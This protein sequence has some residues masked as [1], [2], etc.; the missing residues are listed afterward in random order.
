MPLLPF[1]HYQRRFVR[2]LRER[3]RHS[4]KHP[5]LT[6]TLRVARSRWSLH[7]ISSRRVGLAVAA[8]A[9]LFPTAGLSEPSAQTTA[10]HLY[11]YRVVNVYPHD[12][13]AFTQGLLYRDGFL[14]ESVGLNGRSALRKVELESGEVIQQYTLDSKYFAEGLTDWG[15]RLVQLTWRSKLGFFYDPTSFEIQGTFHYTG[16]GW[17]LTHDRSQLI[18]SDGSATL[19]FLDPE[20]LRVTRHVT[21]RDRG[22]PLQNLNELEFVRGEV[23]ANVWQTDRIARI[24]PRSGRVTGWIDLGGLMP[25]MN[26]RDSVLNGIAYYATHNRLF[27]T[28]K[29]WPRLFEIELVRRQQVR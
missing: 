4:A 29:F 27:V 12:A 14:F 28:G 1:Q 20:T 2:H 11:S 21:V 24:A 13:Q 8:L 22:F 19:R 25:Q 3:G 15:G 26:Q 17:G 5:V 16:E 7:T 9:A 18:L 6:P 10:P 23:Y